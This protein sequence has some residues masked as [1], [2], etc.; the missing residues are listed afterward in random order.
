MTKIYVGNLSYGLTEEQ[1]SEFF[2]GC[3]TISSAIII[4]DRE[5][6]RSKGFGF[7][8]FEEEDALQSALELNGQDLD[9]RP[10]KVSKSHDRPAGGA[11]RRPQRPKRW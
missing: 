10:L 5:T 9:G 3:G 4:K 1:L 2:A 6:G 8:E 11:G 7:V